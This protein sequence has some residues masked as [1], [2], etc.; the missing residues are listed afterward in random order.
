M[1]LASLPFTVA[2]INAPDL[3]HNIRL[4]D[5]IFDSKCEGVLYGFESMQVFCMLK[6]QYAMLPHADWVEQN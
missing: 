1:N 5:M 3:E 6:R 4:A 2:S